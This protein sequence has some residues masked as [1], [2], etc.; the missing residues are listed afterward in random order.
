[1][2]DT[3]SGIF[4]LVLL[5]GVSM[6]CVWAAWL[7]W[8]DSDR[9]PEIPAYRLSQSPSVVRGH[10][11]GVVALAGW[12]VC[13]T[14]GGII[15]AL[16]AGPVHDLVTASF[17]LGSFP[18]LM[19]HATITWFNR[20]KFLVPPHRRDE[21]GSV[22]EWWRRRRDHRAAHQTAARRDA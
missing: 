7:H 20:P 2:A 22:T 11:R 14:T 19:L 13:M 3:S 1:M 21:T 17:I 4:V 8:T 16:G 9:A 10:E 18:L 6:I 15:G 12:L 5:V